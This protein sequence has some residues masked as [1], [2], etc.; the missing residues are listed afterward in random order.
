M[1]NMLK[2]VVSNIFFVAIMSLSK[3]IDRVFAQDPEQKKIL[4][5]EE[6]LQKLPDPVKR[7]LLYTGV[8][9]KPIVQRVRLEQVGRIRKDAQ[10]PWMNFKAKQYYSVIP[11]CFVWI[12]YMKVFG[13]PL[14]RVRDFYMEGRGNILV[15]AFSLFT[16]G[17]SGGKEMD[18]GAMMRYLNEMMWFPSAF[19]GKN[20]SFESI[21][22]NSARV[23]L[24]DMGQSVTATMYFDDKGKLTNFIA[25][26][27]R[28]MGDDKFDLE[29]WSTP[30]REYGEFE[31]L[32]LPI[33][34]AGVWNL[35][36]GDLEYI[37]LTITDL[38]YDPDE[39]Y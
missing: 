20:V 37:D 7:Y 14:V 18:Q 28:D 6:M 16:V 2:A 25:P 30:I 26:R 11:P 39:S 19:L 17:D 13:L 4:V 15:K 3:E 32:K 27:Y 34:G 1:K 12:A 23:T 29:N 10:Q 21:D 36:E 22:A 5:T 38:K 9:G 31:G 24:T 8:V 35:N 33:K